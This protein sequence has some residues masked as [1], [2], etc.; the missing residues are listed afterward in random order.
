MMLFW[1][2]IL[3]PICLVQKLDQQLCLVNLIFLSVLL[4]HQWVDVV[5]SQDQPPELE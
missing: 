3:S 5:Q 1:C 2:D 4:D